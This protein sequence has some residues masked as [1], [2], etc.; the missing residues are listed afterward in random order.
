MATKKIAIVGAGISGLA[1]AWKCRQLDPS[2]DIT[3]FESS[4]KIGGVLQTESVDGYLIEQSADMFV[5]EPDHASKIAEQLGRTADL[6]AT[7]PVNDRAYIAWKD[8]IHPVPEGLSLLLPN[9]L[10]A[11]AKTPLLDEAGKQRFFGER[12]VPPGDKTDESLEHFAVRRFGQQAFERLFQPLV[13]GIYTADPMKLSMRATL[14]RFRKLER[15]HGSL[16]EAAENKKQTSAEKAASGARY[17]I[18]RAPRDGMGCWINWLT[19]DFRDVEIKTD[20]SAETLKQNGNWKLT[21]T[22]AEAYEFDGVILAGSA[23]SSAKL[24]ESLDSRLSTVLSSI[25]AASSAIVV[26]GFDNEQFKQPFGGFGIVF[27]SCL[28]RQIIALSFSSNKFENRAPD[29]KT[30]IRC[31]IGGAM[32]SELVDLPNDDLVR[33]T[34]KEIDSTLGIDGSPELSRVYRWKNCMPQYHLGHLDRVTKIESSVASH[35]GLE[36]VGNS[37]RGVGVPVCLE[38]GCK[39]AERLLEDIQYR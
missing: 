25:N 18:F 33:I 30:L 5:T 4:R 7:R 38:D 19:G 24:V 9:N 22:Q 29:G 36:I 15:E 21:T 35:R 1:S 11:I 23:K 27:P 32:Q 34:M 31:F 14:E 20:C 26:L 12:N 39:A 28:D 37:F 13:S 10:D 16:I 17:S 8:N 6:I 3:I 2:V